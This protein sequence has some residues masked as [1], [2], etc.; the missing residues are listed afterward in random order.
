MSADELK[1]ALRHYTNN[2]AYLLACKEDDARI[3]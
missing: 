2:F 3:A 1:A